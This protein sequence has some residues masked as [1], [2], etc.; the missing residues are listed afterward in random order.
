MYSTKTSKFGDIQ[1]RNFNRPENE[2]PSIAKKFSLGRLGTNVFQLTYNNFA[3]L[4]I[5]LKCAITIALTLTTYFL[6]APL[7]QFTSY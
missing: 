4:L 2:I 6:L 7:G 5:N 1:Y 3:K